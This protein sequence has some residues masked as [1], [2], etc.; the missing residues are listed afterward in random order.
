MASLIY[1]LVKTQNTYACIIPIATSKHIIPIT[2]ARGIKP[3]IKNIKPE[4]IKSNINPPSIAN[5]ICPAK[6][7]APN[8]NPKLNALAKYDINS[9]ITNTGANAKLHP[10]GTNKFR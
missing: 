7:L 4:D 1:E 9:I 3:N 5:K 6:I 8:L 10:D 2:R